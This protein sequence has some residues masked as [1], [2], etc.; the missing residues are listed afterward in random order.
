MPSLNIERH[1]I[2][3]HKIGY[4]IQAFVYSQV[5]QAA[6]KWA[7]IKKKSVQTKANVK[8]SAFLVL[9]KGSQKK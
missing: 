3:S 1:F 8:K 4:V 6:A 9:E 5:L 7:M 2:F